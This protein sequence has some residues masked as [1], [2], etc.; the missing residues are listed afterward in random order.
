MIDDTMHPFLVTA[1]LYSPFCLLDLRPVYVLAM[2]LYNRQNF[3]KLTTGTVFRVVVGPEGR[4]VSLNCGV[5]GHSGGRTVSLR[6]GRSVL[7]GTVSPEGR[8]VSPEGG[9]SVRRVDGQ[10]GGGR[11][12]LEVDGQLL[13]ISD[14]ITDEIE[15]VVSAQRHYDSAVVRVFSVDEV[16]EVVRRHRGG[17]YHRYFL[18]DEIY[19][20]HF[21]PFLPP[22]KKIILWSLFSIFPLILSQQVIGI[23]VL[24][25]DFLKMGLR[26]LNRDIREQSESFGSCQ[27]CE[28][29]A[30]SG[31]PD[32]ALDQ[33]GQKLKSVL[34]R[35][36]RLFWTIVFGVY[37]VDFLALVGLGTIMIFMPFTGFETLCSSCV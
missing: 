19:W 7:R 8:R 24:N 23:F 21:P 33:A 1:F 28:T 29:G 11:S 35:A 10:S 26:D 18:D 5:T 3:E 12:A 25:A 37:G 16:L 20:N 4:M 27:G 32:H 13:D 22:G 36:K 31:K 9:R 2:L 6:S 14:D 34:R 30:E 15:I 17:R